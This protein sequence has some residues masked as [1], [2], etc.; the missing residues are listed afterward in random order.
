MMNEY[1]FFISILFVCLSSL[2][3]VRL[4]KPAVIALVCLNAVLANLFVTKQIALFG[5]CA[6][7]SDTLAIGASIGLN[8]LQEYWDR[9]TARKTIALSF[10]AT[11]FYTIVSQLHLLYV[12]H[13]IDTAHSHFCAL[14]AP[15]PRLIAASLISYGI[16]QWLEYRIYARLKA[17]YHG[18]HFALRNGISL[19]CTQLL[20]TILFSVLGLYGS[21]V[22]SLGALGDIILVSY[23]LKMIVI[24]T[25]V[26]TIAY[27]RRHTIP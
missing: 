11:I 24:F 15:M 21:T 6:T 3:A 23:I 20:D 26:P 1:I 2:L 10:Y 16:V 9:E 14:L 13:S 22:T 17:R 25:A 8:L 12:P 19:S 27:V 4:G 7:A 18:A 5:L